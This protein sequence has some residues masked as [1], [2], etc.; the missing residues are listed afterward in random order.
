MTTV[1]RD[2]PLISFVNVWSE[3]DKS[4]MVQD[5]DAAIPVNEIINYAASVRNGNITSEYKDN[6]ADNPPE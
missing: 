1:T 3:R 2:Q 4:G 5:D 6:L